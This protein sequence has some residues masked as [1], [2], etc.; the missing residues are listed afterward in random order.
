MKSLRLVAAIFVGLLLPQLG[1]GH[2]SRPLYVELEALDDGAYLLAW[3][4]PPSIALVDI[5]ALNLGPDCTASGPA[6]PASYR[7][8][9]QR[10]FHCAAEAGPT[11]L[12]LD[13][14]GANPSLSTMVRYQR[15]QGQPL[16]IHAAPDVNPVTLGNAGGMQGTLWQYLQLGVRHIAGGYDHLLFVACLLLLALNLRRLLLAITGFTLAHSITLALAA[17]DVWRVPVVP[18]EAVIALS[19]LF[20]AAEL[21]RQQKHTLAWRYPALVAT[22][23]G[24]LHGFGFASVLAEIGLPQGEV[25][26]ALLG[27]NLGVE[28]GQLAFVGLLLVLGAGWR[29]RVQRPLGLTSS[30]ATMVAAYPIG[31]LACFWFWQRLSEFA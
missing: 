15:L 7:R 11:S 5:P 20:L 26:V 9:N 18:T 30:A 12:M 4:V 31:V 17:L 19:I 6:E 1:Q 23:F 22:L 29:A 21:A 8:A 25:V 3:K 27:F 14:P 10:L 24:L 16:V 2:D 28:V 13:Y